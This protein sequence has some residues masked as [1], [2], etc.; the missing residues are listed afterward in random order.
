MTH[1]I[2]ATLAVSSRRRKS[3]LLMLVMGIVSV[4]LCC[5][6]LTVLAIHDRVR[7][8]R[9][10]SNQPQRHGMVIHSQLGAMCIHTQTTILI[11]T[12]VIETH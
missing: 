1:E 9:Q 4:I 5:P 8:H 6:C 7:S 11:V 3:F 12:V 2:S 10:V